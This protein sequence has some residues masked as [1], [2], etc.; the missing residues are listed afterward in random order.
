MSEGAGLYIHV[1]FCRRRCPYC[2][3]Y[4]VTTLSYRDAFVEAVRRELILWAPQ[5]QQVRFDTLYFGGGTPS[6]LSV[7]QLER[8][9]EAVHRHLHLEPLEVTLEA[10]P[11]DL[12]PEYLRALRRLGFTRLSLGVQA[13]Q[14][15][16]LRF[17]GR[18]HGQEDVRRALDWIEK[19]GF[20][21]YNLD[22]IFG[23]PGEEAPMWD[24]ELKTLLA[25]RPPHVSC[26]SLTVE[27]RTVLSRAI[28]RGL[29]PSPDETRQAELFL[30]THARLSEAGY[31]HY[32]V[33]NY[34]LCG[35]EARH[36]SKYWRHRPYLGLGPSAHSF[37][38]LGPDRAERWAN[39]RSLR[40]YLTLLDAHQ[41]PI[42]E[43]ETLG[44]EALLTE[45]LLLGLRLREG[46]SLAELAAR[47]GWKPHAG[48]RRLIRAWIRRGWADFRDERLRLTPT[49]WLLTD[50]LVLELMPSA[51]HPQAIKH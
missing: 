4:L 7:E 41:L 12:S 14:E 31:L 33:S 24:A 9:M 26:Y 2:D 16:R 5:W 51:S 48:H 19:L 23:L 11:E 21:S 36:N 8:I 1:P 43:R 15:S 38:W 37:R 13:F 44:P 6:Q 45:A 10:N 42:E 34:A 28:A 47:Y 3:F 49:G 40:R 39:V 32:E 20:S 22:L 30:Q 29:V 27:P 17:L 50:S 35:H 46:V 25:L 18:Q